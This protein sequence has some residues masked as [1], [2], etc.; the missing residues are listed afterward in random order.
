MNT[1]KK[2]NLIQ[3]KKIFV[4]NESTPRYGL[5]PS[6]NL[7]DALWWWDRTRKMILPKKREGSHELAAS[8]PSSI[9]AFSE[10]LPTGFLTTTASP[11]G[12][13]IASSLN[14]KKFNLSL[15]GDQFAQRTDQSFALYKILF[16]QP[17]TGDD[18]EAKIGP[19]DIVWFT[20]FISS[21][22]DSKISSCSFSQRASPVT[23]FNNL[24]LVGQFSSFNSSISLLL[25]FRWSDD[26][27]WTSFFSFHSFLRLFNHFISIQT[28]I[29]SKSTPV[30][31]QHFYLIPALSP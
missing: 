24:P 27:R 3:T 12:T 14:Q 23:F 22:K 10:T 29:G 1:K 5:H 21:S 18:Q 20:N 19:M 28:R 16:N 6:L 9:S 30:E 17:N 15:N 31:S 11:V 8:P 7:C 4:D 13:P 2:I 26:F 25:I